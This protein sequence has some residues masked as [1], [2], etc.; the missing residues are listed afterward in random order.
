[1]PEPA[2]SAEPL[3][4]STPEGHTCSSPSS[5][6]GPADPEDL[7]VLESSPN[8]PGSS[9]VARFK[10]VAP[11]PSATGVPARLSSF[12]FRGKP[13]TAAAAAAA[14]TI[15]FARTESED[16]LPKPEKSRTPVASTAINFTRMGISTPAASGGSSRMAPADFGKVIG[17]FKWNADGS[18]SDSSDGDGH[19]SVQSSRSSSRKRCVAELDSPEDAR[20]H[21]TAARKRAATPIALPSD[22]DDEDVIEVVPRR[23]R[24]Q[25][26]SRPPA[27]ASALPE[28][29]PPSSPQPPA[30]TRRTLAARRP[31]AAIDVDSGDD[32]ASGDDATGGSLARRSF[33]SIEPHVMR[34]FND[35]SAEELAEKTG[36]TPDEVAIIQGLRPFAD[37][38]AVE[39]QLRKTRGVRLALFNQYRDTVLGHAEVE[40]VIGQCAGIFSQLKATMRRAGVETNEATGAVSMAQGVAL[41]APQ[42]VSSAFALKHYQLE[43]VQWLDCLR[44]AGASGILADEMGLGKTFQVIAFLCKGIED[45]RVR[46][47]ALVVCPSST[48]D[49]WLNECA[50]FAPTLRVAAYYGLQAERMALQA[51][52]DDE[53]RYDVMVTTYN[54]ATGNKMD[55]IFLKKR[56]FHSLVL[57]EG[58]MVKNCMSSRYKWLMQ[59]RAPFRLLL[60]GTPLQ[61]N[62]QEL[63]SLL[64][65]ILPQVF[66]DSQPML[67]HAFKSKPSA[68]GTQTKR[69]LSAATSSSV[70]AT[71][72]DD[73][74]A[75]SSLA[76][77]GAQS[78]APQPAAVGA[79][80]AQHIAQAKTL[81]R[82]FVLRR[83]KCDVLADLP[84]KTEIIVRLDLTDSQRTLYDSIVPDDEGSA[85]SIRLNL[86]KLDGA[87]LDTASDTAAESRAAVPAV[88]KG[89]MAASWISTFMNMRKVADHPLLLR[90]LYDLPQLA[91]MAKAL[92]REP[93]YASAEYKFLLEDMEV[94]SDFELHQLCVKYPKIRSFRLP[95]EAL[96]NS[97][98]VRKL[99]EIVDECVER[100]EKLLLFSQFTSMLNILEAVF[101]L[102]SIDY[103]RLDGQTKVDERQTMIDEFNSDSSRLPVFLLST[104]AGGFGINLTS[105]NVVV[106]YDA[107]N[108]PS[109]ERQAEDR[110]HRVGQ[111]KDVRV[112]KLIGSGTIDEAI[113]ETSRS[114]LLVEHMFWV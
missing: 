93:D 29:S 95:D 50:K 83:R 54:V 62:L 11:P 13:P 58:H 31:V 70:A 2:S 36:A 108:N 8:R 75:A 5:T 47:P 105:A 84:S 10:D 109:E 71:D 20:R 113:W 22:S 37:M 56:R 104:K 51:R 79:V 91:K 85:E 98:K 80:E 16:S 88:S 18:I 92:L 26:G 57:D 107:G 82:P 78:P 110:A 66:A 114:K 96:L 106:I 44:N 68:G 67:S 89:T 43:G 69:S 7:V 63:V 111:V 4:P 65:F 53:S 61:N 112:Y 64:T 100:G 40:A 19:A 23:G 99:R 46:G 87:Q 102:W 1:M 59:I 42:M 74:T 48:L 21:P 73:A 9:R 30:P 6:L 101:Q 3:A 49:N 14:A 72:S 28:S 24:L 55:R 77:S 25:R 12:Y 86:M 32:D 94:C 103:C 90:S 17:Q 81:L 35:G 15:A 52:L 38:E 27:A 39:Q 60:T 76:P 45:A 97:A 34:L 33:G 41:A